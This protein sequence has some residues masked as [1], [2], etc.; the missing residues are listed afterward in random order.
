VSV[1]A[2]AGVRNRIST[3]LNWFWAYLTFG[4]GIRLITGDKSGQEE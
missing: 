1:D 3:M 2:L 4:G